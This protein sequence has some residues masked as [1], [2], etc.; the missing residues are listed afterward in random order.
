LFGFVVLHFCIQEPVICFGSLNS[1]ELSSLV[2]TKRVV[3]PTNFDHQAK[4]QN[5]QKEVTSTAQTTTNKH[6]T[7]PVSSV[8]SSGTPKKKVSKWSDLFDH[9]SPVGNGFAI[10]EEVPNEPN[11]H[12]TQLKGLFCLSV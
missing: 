3:L 10:H 11:E 9:S 7:F 4:N 8:P 12:K 2:Q 5:P 6:E 1:Q